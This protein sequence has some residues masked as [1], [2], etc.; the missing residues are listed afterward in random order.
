ML[1]FGQFGNNPAKVIRKKL[2]I[3]I[4]Q[5]KEPELMPLSVMYNFTNYG[6]KEGMSHIESHSVLV[7]SRQLIWIGT[8]G[9]GVNVYD[10]NQIKS[11]NKND[12]LPSNII[13]TILEDYSGSIWLA[14][15]GGLSMFDGRTFTTKVD[16]SRMDGDEIVK[17]IAHG[18]NN[19]LWIGTSEKGVYQYDIASDSILLRLSPDQLISDE[20]VLIHGLTEDHQGNLWVALNRK[21]ICKYS[22]GQFTRY[23]SDN[24]NLAHDQVRHV[25]CDSKGRIWASTGVGVSVFDKGHFTSYTEKDGLV[26][27]YNRSSFEDSKGNIYFC[28]FGDG[29]SVYND[30]KGFFQTYTQNEGF[31]A[32]W[33]SAIDEDENGNLW[34]STLYNG[35]IKKENEAFTY[36]YPDFNDPD[37]FVYE[38]LEDQ[39]GTFWF[40][41]QKGLVKYEDGKMYR[42]GIEQ[43]LPTEYILEIAE[44]SKGN[45]WLGT[46]SQGLYYFDGH[47]IKWFKH[48][49]EN[50]LSGANI[51]GLQVDNEDRVWAAT[52]GG[53]NTIKDDS[54][55]WYNKQQG[56][57]YYLTNEFFIDRTGNKW[58]G[59]FGGGVSLI[60]SEKTPKD[61]SQFIRL[62]KESGHLASNYVPVISQDRDGNI[63]LGNSGQEIVVIKSNWKEIKDTNDWFI[64]IG[65]EDGLTDA[66]IEFMIEDDYGDIWIGT[67]SGLDRL[68]DAS[69]SLSNKS[70]KFRHYGFQEGY[71]GITSIRHSCFKDSKGYLWFGASNFIT[72]YNPDIKDID[73]PP[74]VLRLTN[75]KLHFENP[76]WDKIEDAALENY[77]KWDF[78]PQG[79]SLPYNEN[80]ITFEFIG[81]THYLSQNVQ[82]QWKLEGFDDEWT[83]LSKE[84]KATYSGLPA[85]EYTFAVKCFGANDK[86]SELVYS[87]EIRPPFWQTWWFRTIIIVGILCVIFLFFQWRT[88]NLRKRQVVLENTVQKRTKEV[89]E[90]KE[91]LEEQHQEI[92][93]S[94][95]YAQRI[96]DAILPP[97]DVVGEVIPNHFIY[98]KPKDVVAGDF[99]W[100]ESQ[101]DL[102]LLAAAD[103]TGHGV[104]GAMVSV[105]CHNALNRAVREF[106]LKEPHLIL[107]K[108]RELVIETL[109]Q[110][111]KEVKDGMDVSLIRILNKK[112]HF[113]G[114]NNPL[115]IIRKT[116]YLTQGEKE[117]KSTLIS[118][119]LAL[120][121]MKAD[122]QPIGLYA[123]MK[124]FTLNE[125]ELKEGDVLYL[126]TDGYA[127]QFGGEKGKKL[128]YK[129]F[130]QILL[131][132]QELP[133][134]Q[135]KEKLDQLFDQW[136]GDYEQ[137]D[138][139]CIIGVRI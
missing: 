25:M 28:S 134:A 78:I 13:W 109:A 138:D 88:R 139:V 51:T 117:A 129:P 136:K 37:M 36:Y 92:M 103:C 122:K 16:S 66:N 131:D 135:Q 29:I 65:Y 126:F 137:V 96:Q 18:K 120:L 38:I 130:K 41:T 101:V 46:F 118:D 75:I 132:L 116:E 104:P 85:G 39:N 6:I 74:P 4:R 54:L 59:T 14:T 11:Y 12:G 125:V 47:S 77:S 44:D 60:P 70:F 110:H 57:S 22:N 106:Q 10:G 34:I 68:F 128:K 107:N 63:W 72:R 80:H 62:M 17:C 61:T 82:Y 115:W 97:T 111:S 45:L 23:N 121:E 87:F 64:R 42:W 27:N 86:S 76:E 30:E 71:K 5:L 56:L 79:L 31:D 90:Q 9:G 94:I 24:S 123:G 35:V 108:T 73:Q 15:D 7:D 84:H 91:L 33:V 2:D 52:S 21:G 100:F 50:G 105:V 69:S 113:A 1:L 133:L 102:T 119:D 89:H 49:W 93:D 58:V 53:V 3:E 48:N 8:Y 83:P 55:S 32:H 20:M 124:D 99:Y 40:G 43:G 127:D 67:P 19:T 98:Y 26:H 114:A 81:V 112:V 95:A